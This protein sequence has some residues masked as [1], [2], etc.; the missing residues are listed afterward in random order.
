MAYYNLYTEYFPQK[1]KINLCSTA[2]GIENV[3]IDYFS[4]VFRFTK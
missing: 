4:Q 2:I 3:T 1:L